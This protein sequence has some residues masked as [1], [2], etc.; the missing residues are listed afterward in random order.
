M[1][2]VTPGITAPEGSVT[3]PSIVPKMVCANNGIAKKKAH[4]AKLSAMTKGLVRIGKSPVSKLSKTL[5]LH[6][7]CG[8]AKAGF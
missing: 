7:G 6:R 4:A 5:P 1:V 3:V 2:T 8:K